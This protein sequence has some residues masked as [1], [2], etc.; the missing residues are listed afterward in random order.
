MNI[1]R[2][3]SMNEEDSLATVGYLFISL[4]E[5]ISLIEEMQQPKDPKTSK[6]AESRYQEDAQEE[7]ETIAAEIYL[8]LTGLK[9]EK[10]VVPLPKK[11]RVPACDVKIRNIDR[12]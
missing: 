7:I 6:D 8:A 4:N 1:T 10:T 11:V 12:I 5:A 9:I 3:I 2:Q